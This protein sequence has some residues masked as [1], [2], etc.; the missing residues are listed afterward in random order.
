M[1]YE[2]G[3]PRLSTIIDHIVKSGNCYINYVHRLLSDELR[4]YHGTQNRTDGLIMT[5]FLRKIKARFY[6]LTRKTLGGTHYTSIHKV[7]TH[8]T[9]STVVGFT[10]SVKH[11]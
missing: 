6:E 1:K 11:T 8:H 9:G 3:G 5:E 7:V 2:D 4:K 10:S